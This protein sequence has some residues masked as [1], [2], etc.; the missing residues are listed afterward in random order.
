MPKLIDVE[1]K[2]CGAYIE[3]SKAVKINTKT[4]EYEYLCDNCAIK[5][6]EKK[7]DQIDYVDP[8][9]KRNEDQP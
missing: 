1:C 7:G 4:G 8:I 6:K 9:A 2:Y 5:W 3:M